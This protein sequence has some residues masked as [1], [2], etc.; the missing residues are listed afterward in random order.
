MHYS[1]SRISSRVFMIRRG[2]IPSEVNLIR[3]G[4]LLRHSRPDGENRE[5]GVKERLACPGIESGSSK[6]QL[7]RSNYTGKVDG[8]TMY[9]FHH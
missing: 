1:S 8:K 9:Y 4:C 6:C 7:P 5:I 3:F 2:K